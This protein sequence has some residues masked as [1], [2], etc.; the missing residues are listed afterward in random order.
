MAKLPQRQS[1]I[2]H[3]F[4]GAIERGEK[5]Y[6][7]SMLLN[8]EH[9]QNFC[10]WALRIVARDER[11]PVRLLALTSAKGWAKPAQKNVQKIFC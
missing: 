6:D 4:T 2:V 9:V 1:A 7:L 11:Q 3:S 8:S 5:T 10:R